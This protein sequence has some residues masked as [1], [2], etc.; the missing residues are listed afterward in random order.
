MYVTLPLATCRS[1]R[2]MIA[3]ISLGGK[4]DTRPLQ[5]M[6]YVSLVGFAISECRRDWRAG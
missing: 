6:A 2:A 5:R 4:M 3:A 1:M